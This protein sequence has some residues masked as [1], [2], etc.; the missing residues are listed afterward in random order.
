MTEIKKKILLENAYE[1]WSEAVLYAWLLKDAV[2]ETVRMQ[3]IC[4]IPRITIRALSSL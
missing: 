1:A 2:W 4:L 3:E